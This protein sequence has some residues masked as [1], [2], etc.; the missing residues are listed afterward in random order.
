LAN[1][2][3]DI[4]MHAKGVP[5]SHVV[6][7]VKDKLPSE[8]VIKKAAEIAAK[9]CKSKEDKVRVLYCKKKFV[10]KEKGMNPG[11]VK[12]DYVNANEIVIN[13]K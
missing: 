13:K 3:E 9:N 7:K 2:P 4:W 10:K 6:I 11:Q 8:E 1:D 5:G 12:V